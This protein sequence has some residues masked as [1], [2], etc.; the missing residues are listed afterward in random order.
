MSLL[1]L[2][3]DYYEIFLSY[4][5]ASNRGTVGRVARQFSIPPARLTDLFPSFPQANITLSRDY[6]PGVDNRTFSKTI[7]MKVPFSHPNG[8]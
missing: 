1:W 2:S 4:C 3:K 6:I 8:R 7:D 5:S